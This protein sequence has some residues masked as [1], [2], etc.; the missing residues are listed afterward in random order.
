MGGRTLREFVIAAVTAPVLCDFL[1]V[2]IFGNSALRKVLDGDTAFAHLAMTNPQRGWY[3]L[4]ES[5]PGAP[6]LVGLATL[7][8]LLFYLTSANSGA[9]VMANFSSSIPDPAKD[10]SRWLRIYWALLTALLTVAMLVAGGVTTMEYATLIFALPVT[11]IAYLVMASF[12]KVL[13]MERA[14]R[15]GRTLRR[16]RVAVDGGQAPEKSWRQ[17]LAGL[18]AYPSK[19]AVVQFSNQ[20]VQPALQD[21]CAEFTALGHRASLITVP[22]LRTGVPEHRLTVEFAHGQRDF[23]YRVAAVEAAVPLFGARSMRQGSDVYLRLEVFIQT[24]SEGY[25]LVGLTRQQVI[26]DVLDRYEAH[27]AFLQYSSEHDYDSVLTPPRP[28]STATPP[29]GE[30]EDAADTPEPPVR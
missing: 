3:A 13:R 1:I 19:A 25:D 8:G 16:R 29:P 14:D 9:M 5:F 30:P 22:D 18:R 7:S 27:L 12:S 4:L 11:I 10:G 26:D 21:V 20:V 15:E 23:H 2:C 28:A 24:G 6:F 17:R